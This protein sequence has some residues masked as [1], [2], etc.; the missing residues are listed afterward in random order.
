MSS[1]KG[2]LASRSL[3][4]RAPEVP[5]FLKALKAQ[6]ASSDRY[7][8][9]SSSK[10][11]G[12][13]LDSFVT[14]TSSGKRKAHDDEDG[15]DVGLDSDDE[16]N[17]AQVVV[18]KDGKHLSHSEA[19][20]HKKTKAAASNATSSLSE[21]SAAG[22]AQNIAASA[23]ATPSKRRRDPIGAPS[24]EPS[25]LSVDSII[26]R[27]TSQKIKVGSAKGTLEDVKQLIRQDRQSRAPTSQSFTK[28]DKTEK[29]K[30]DK[31]KEKNA[32]ARKLK[33]QSGKG[34]SF[35]LDD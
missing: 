31:R 9:S 29:T 13:E 19:L 21:N 25:H 10:R 16:M 17:G 24:S 3:E 15:E 7:S 35:D 28:E 22:K 6:V 18:L 4:Y 14:S 8:S 20:Q 30:Q 27:P 32:H 11:G 26:N 23:S 2:N 5:S 33:A 1:R 12:D 34:L